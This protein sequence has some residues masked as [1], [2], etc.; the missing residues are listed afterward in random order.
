MIRIAPAFGVLLALAG[1]ASA[2]EPSFTIEPTEACLGNGPDSDPRA[3]IGLAAAACA[4]PFGFATPVESFCNEQEYLYWE[5]RLEAAW[6]SLG[7]DNAAEDAE[8]AAQGVPM[9]PL[10]PALQALRDGFTPYRDAYCGYMMAQ[11]RG[12]T[13]QGPA[14]TYCLMWKTG[15]MALDL[16]G[17]QASA[18]A[19]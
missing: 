18:E 4:E 3:C 12:G 19:P 9:P 6:T 10:A 16:E 13:G 7:E 8:A 17:W 2:Q 14:L 5:A 15:E 1:P 11:Y